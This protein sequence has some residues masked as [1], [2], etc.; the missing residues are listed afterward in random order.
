MATKP[1]IAIFVHAGD[2]G[3]TVFSTAC[4]RQEQRQLDSWLLEN[5][6]LDRLVQ[7]AWALADLSEEPR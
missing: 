4:S 6:D 2:T 3:P 7:L 1:S 5:P